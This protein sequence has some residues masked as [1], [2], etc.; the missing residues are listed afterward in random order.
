MRKFRCIAVVMEWVGNDIIEKWDAEEFIVAEDEVEAKH[1]FLDGIEEQYENH[2]VELDI[3]DINIWDMGPAD[4]VL[5]VRLMSY[6][7]LGDTMTAGELCRYLDE[8]FDPDTKIYFGE[9][10]GMVATYGYINEDCFEY[11]GYEGEE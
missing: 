10:S 7:A 3:D 8:N 6:S 5:S 4:L 9:Y 11:A 1:K 2:D